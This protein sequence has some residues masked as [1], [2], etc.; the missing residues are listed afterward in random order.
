M[1]METG[2]SEA[3]SG[4]VPSRPGRKRKAGTAGL[5]FAASNH[6]QFFANT[7]SAGISLPE[8]GADDEQLVDRGVTTL[9]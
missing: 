5:A 2:V 6:L 3:T 7:P 9:L 1:A 4:T 8:F